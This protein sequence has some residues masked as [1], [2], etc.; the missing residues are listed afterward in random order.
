MSIDFDTMSLKEMRDLRV[1]LDRAIN[2]YEDRKRREAMSAVEEAAREH[3]FNLAELTGTKTKRAGSV[4]PKYANPTDPTMTW[5]G[6]G[7]K[8]K[9]VQESLD[10][11]KELDDLLI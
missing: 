3:G 8:P 1:K 11:G 2:S 9:W 5:T 6:R 7:R 10:G 4:A